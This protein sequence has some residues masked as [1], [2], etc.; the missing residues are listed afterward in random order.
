MNWNEAFTE[1]IVDI[2]K[3]SLV[4]INISSFTIQEVLNEKGL[5]DASMRMDVSMSNDPE[6]V[7]SLVNTF[8]NNSPKRDDMLDTAMKSAIASLFLTGLR[9]SMAQVKQ[10]KLQQEKDAS[11]KDKQPAN[12][13]KRIRNRKPVKK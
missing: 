7:M 12:P 2:K 6:N 3:N 8:T 10:A 11:K 5:Y 9:T 1:L 13:A 4:D